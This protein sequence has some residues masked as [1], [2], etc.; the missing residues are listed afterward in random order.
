VNLDTDK[1]FSILAHFSDASGGVC[2]RL[3]HQIRRDPFAVGIVG[4][5]FVPVPESSVNG[6]GG[7]DS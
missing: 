3:L 4:A 2:G 1:M 5:A 7:R 6:S